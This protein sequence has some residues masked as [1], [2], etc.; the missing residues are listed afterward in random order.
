MPTISPSSDCSSFSGCP[1]S[2]GC[3]SSSSPVTSV[4]AVLVAQVMSEIPS[5]QGCICFDQHGFTVAESGV[6]PQGAVTV[7]NIAK[8]VSALAHHANAEDPSIIPRPPIV[9]F[10]TTHKS[11]LNAHAC[12][13]VHV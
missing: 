2:P 13:H 7:V 11:Q 8:Q 9:C 6:V 4:S 5:A 1:S 3:S 10:E 12:A